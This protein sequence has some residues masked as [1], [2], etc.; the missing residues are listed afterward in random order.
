MSKRTPKI[1]FCINT[2]RS[3]SAYIGSL[4]KGF[5]N[6]ESFH[7]PK[8]SLCGKRMRDYQLGNKNA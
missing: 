3:G 4:L 6:I 2:G 7:E 8:P 1:I 5:S